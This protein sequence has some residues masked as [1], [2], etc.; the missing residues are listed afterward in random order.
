[1]NPIQKPS[2]PF[3]VLQELQVLDHKWLVNTPWLWETKIHYVVTYALLLNAVTLIL[4][5][6]SLV[7]T[8][9][10]SGI[11]TLIGLGFWLYHL[12]QFSIEQDRGEAGKK[13]AQKRFG[14]YFIGMFL[15][16]L[17]NYLAYLVDTDFTQ[18]IILLVMHNTLLAGI[19]AIL[20]QLWKQIQT[21]LFIYTLVANALFATVL[22]L[23]INI[24][25]FFIVLIV[26]LLIFGFPALI[27]LITDVPKIKQF[28]VWKVIA[29]ASIQLYAPFL[30]SFVMGVFLIPF[31]QLLSSAVMLVG[32]AVA[33]YSYIAYVLPT[34]RSMHI[35]MQSLP[36]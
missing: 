17:P 36:R 32:V 3:P 8:P 27:S 4:S 26:A 14:I 19:G 30:L 35:H 11:F 12:W 21:K 24:S 13:V 25:S 29:L 15:L 10:I 28:S 6:W 5:L 16:L 1:M 31:I 33:M 18:P 7:I 2:S 34:F 22:G 23:I 20:V 9:V